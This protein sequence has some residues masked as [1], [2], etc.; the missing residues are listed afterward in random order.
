MG[1]GFGIYQK[2]EVGYFKSPAV[3]NSFGIIVNVDKK[4][5][6]LYK[7]SRLFRRYPVALGASETPT[8]EGSFVILEK[9]LDAGEYFLGFAKR[10]NP[11]GI[12]IDYCGIHGTSDPAPLNFQYSKGCVLMRAPDLAELALFVAEGMPVIIRD[13]K[14]Q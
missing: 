5:L 13:R 9:K 10:W 7:G 3:G 8:P 14:A 4:V 1:D 6:L 2:S 11:S 12:G